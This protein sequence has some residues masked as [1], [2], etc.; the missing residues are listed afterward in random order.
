MGV[1]PAGAWASCPRLP[2]RSG[3][4]PPQR[5]R[6]PCYVRGIAAFTFMSHTPCRTGCD[7]KGTTRTRKP[8]NYHSFHQHRLRKTHKSL[9][10]INIVSDTACKISPPLVFNNI[11]A[12]HVVLGAPF[13]SFPLFHKNSANSF[14]FNRP[15]LI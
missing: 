15:F 10:F 14:F 1:P 7:A 5:A 4:L 9:V 13:F 11:P 2:G 8:T 12:S 6:R 3:T